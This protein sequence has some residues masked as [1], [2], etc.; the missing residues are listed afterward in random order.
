MHPIIEQIVHR[1]DARG[2]HRYGTEAVSQMQHAL[3][4]ARLAELEGAPS[5]LV[6]AALLHDIGH[7][8]T[9][10]TSGASADNLD[11][12]HEHHAYEWLLEAFGPAVADPVRLHVLAK[13]YLCTIDP[14][15]VD[16][17]SPTS[18]KSYIDQGGPMSDEERA[19]FQDEP[20]HL[21]ALRL[22]RW[23]DR[24]KEPGRSTQPLAYFL[25]HVESCLRERDG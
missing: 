5:E 7:L 15:Y 24:A 6:A 4:S 3:Q 19:V 22:R 23:D 1:F 12:S 18:Y 8:L 20:Y 25:P 21:E 16:A 2:N 11:D 10:E 17:L 9:P 14:G 13:R